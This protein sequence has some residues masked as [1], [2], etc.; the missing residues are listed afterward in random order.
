[1]DRFRYWFTGAL[2]DVFMDTR[3]YHFSPVTGRIDM[4]RNEGESIQLAVRTECPVQV[5]VK[6]QPFAEENAPRIESGLVHFAFASAQSYDIGRKAI[7]GKTPCEFPEY[8]NPLETVDLAEGEARSFFITAWTQADTK[9]GEYCTTIHM[10][11]GDC[12]W[13]IPLTVRVRDVLIPSAIESDYSYTCWLSMTTK[14][15]PQP[16]RDRKD[17]QINEK[18]FGIKNYSEEFWKLAENYARALKRHRQDVITVPFHDLLVEEMQIDDNGNYI[19]DFTLFD[20]YVEIFLKHGAFRYLEGYHL[21]FRDFTFHPPKPGEWSLSSIVCW[22]FEKG[23]DGKVKIGWRQFEDPET[24]RHLRQLLGGLYAHLKEKGWDKM[25]LQHVSDEMTSDLQLNQTRWGYEIVHECMPGARTIDAVSGRSIEFFGTELDIHVPILYAFESA[26]EEMVA[27]AAANPSVEM[28]NYTC[29][30]PHQDYLSR[31]GDYKLICTRL[32]H[33]YNYKWNATGYLHWAWNTW[34]CGMVRWDPFADTSTIDKG[35]PTDGW[36][37]FPDRENLDV[38]ETTRSHA[39]R[40]GLEDRELLRLAAQKDPEAVKML[41]DVMLVDARDYDT[42]PNTF[43]RIRE[44]L[45]DIA[46]RE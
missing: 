12:A 2:E 23:D 39:N 45:L 16:G 19:F 44:K 7:R 5:T 36:L 1:M 17:I 13:E 28:W 22:V 30:L 25:W 38:W 24:E 40:D 14:T 21:F 34:G 33:W 35:Y 37:V 15:P 8:I 43:M 46:E 6:V 3:P 20:R 9:P 18:I 4:A 42:D 31:L 29:M 26:K 27:F 41:M 10:T 32:L 11:A